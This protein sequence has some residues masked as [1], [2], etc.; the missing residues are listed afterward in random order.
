MTQVIAADE[1]IVDATLARVN[2]DGL[3]AVTRD[4]AI[5]LRDGRIAWFG[6]SRDIPEEFADATRSNLGSRLITPGLIECHTHLVHAGDRNDERQERK[7]GD[8]TYE[9]QLARGGAIHATVRDTRAATEDELFQSAMKRARAF[10]AQ[11]V[12]TLEIKS[13]Y[14]LDV[15]TELMML[16]VATRIGADLELDVIRTLLAGHTYPLDG[17]REAFVEFVCQSLLPAAREA[18]LMDCVEVCCDD[19]VGLDL[20]DASTI[21]ETAYRWKIPTRMQADFL[22]DSAGSALAPAFYAKAAAHLLNTD[23]LAIKA[24][25]ASHTA[26]VLLP[27]AAYELGLEARPPIEELREERVPMAVS[28][29]YNPGTAPVPDLLAAARL[30][31]ELFGLTQEEA[32][33]GITRSAA[34]ALDLNE[35]QG[36]IRVGGLAD[37]AIWNATSPRDILSDCGDALCWATLKGRRGPVAGQLQRGARDL[38]GAL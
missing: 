14:G 36:D 7:R 34:S 28:S 24:L 6:R 26:A 35:G 19:S 30:A 4:A 29:G 22:A 18:G 37:F 21:L 25:A 27:I 17:D 15:I 13:G 20:D 12:T 33:I 1:L 11:G 32:F 23:A 31:I 10:A 38:A 9:E 8:T 16:R 5:A 3:F 2:E